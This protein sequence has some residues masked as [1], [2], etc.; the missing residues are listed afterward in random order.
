MTSEEPNSPARGPAPNPFSTRFV[1][2]GA[3]PYLFPEGTSAD[4]L[5]RRLAELGWQGEIVGPHGSGK[6]TLLA[7]LVGAL[8]RQGRKLALIVLREGDRRLPK[9]VWRQIREKTLDLLIV[10]GFEQLSWFTRRRLKAAC[11]RN[12]LGL[13]T[14]SHLSTG[15]PTLFETHTS[16]EITRQIVGELLAGQALDIADEEIDR[17]YFRS[18][19]NVRETLFALYDLAERRQSP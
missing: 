12:R 9:E 18:G 8:E 14:T 5:A 19:G 2:P 17:C 13:L 10:D 4:S 16:P 11:Q 3:I 6:S 7:S 1:R 15:L